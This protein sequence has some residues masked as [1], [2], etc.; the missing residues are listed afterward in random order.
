A[1]LAGDDLGD[2]LRGR[3]AVAN[4]HLDF[5]DACGAGRERIEDA[6][7]LFQRLRD[8][9]GEAQAWWALKS[10]HYG[11]GQ[12]GAAGDAATCMLE[13]ARRAGS[14]ALA[15]RAAVALAACLVGGPT[16]VSEALPRV[17]ALRRETTNRRT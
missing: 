16:P 10:W 3:I 14:Q 8:P 7:A 12:I 15:S 1:A 5:V 11:I 4:A 9:A 17:L 13:C 6:I 2:A